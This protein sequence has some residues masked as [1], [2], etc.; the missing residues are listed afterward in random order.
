[1][2]LFPVQLL[3]YLITGIAVCKNY[4]VSQQIPEMMSASY[5][6]I[7]ACWQI[8]CIWKMYF[9]VGTAEL[10]LILESE[11]FDPA[12]KDLEMTICKKDLGIR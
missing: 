11:C 10:S 3:F 4:L 7:K 8:L 2:Y 6:G 5:M 9:V 1:M 12:L